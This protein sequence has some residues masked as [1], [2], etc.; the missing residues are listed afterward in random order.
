MERLSE[1]RWSGGGDL[2]PGRWV[3][4]GL[5]CY[6]PEGEACREIFE[7]CAVREGPVRELSS[8]SDNDI[9]FLKGPTIGFYQLV[10][11]EP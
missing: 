11:C 5:V 3:Y 7:K 4:K 6:L 8:V 1:T 2:E 9:E 10:S